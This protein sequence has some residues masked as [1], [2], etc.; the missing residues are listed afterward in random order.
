MISA[1]PG[2]FTKTGAGPFV[3]FFQKDSHATRALCGT[4]WRKFIDI[5]SR[6]SRHP[7]V[8]SHGRF[9]RP[10]PIGRLF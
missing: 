4:R 5:K 3:L 1:G 2:H 8:G 10:T 9:S 7:L 6:L